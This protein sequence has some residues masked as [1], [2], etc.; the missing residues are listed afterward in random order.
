MNIDNI[1]YLKNI[2]GEDE[3]KKYLTA[4]EEKRKMLVKVLKKTSISRVLC[5]MGKF[6]VGVEIPFEYQM[7]LIDYMN[8][9]YNHEMEYKKLFQRV[10]NF[11]EFLPIIFEYHEQIEL[12]VEQEIETVNEDKITIDE[13]MKNGGSVEALIDVLLKGEIKDFNGNTRIPVFLLE[14]NIKK[15]V[16]NIPQIGYLVSIMS[17]LDLGK[18]TQRELL[19][20]Y[21]KGLE[22]SKQNGFSTDSLMVEDKPRLYRL[23]KNRG[24]T[25]N[26]LETKRDN[27]YV[28]RLKKH[29]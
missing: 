16:V 10:K 28:K 21:Y 3:V 6:K 27:L 7:F 18:E 2:L 13:F 8:L 11:A 24:L 12:L 9:G 14:T 4:D 22:Q 20:V 23:L 25:A 17:S 1:V 19:E 15:Y 26:V 29:T 5:V